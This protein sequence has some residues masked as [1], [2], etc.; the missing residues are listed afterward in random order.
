M[1]KDVDYLVVFQEYIGEVFGEDGES[2]KGVSPDDFLG[3]IDELVEVSEPVDEAS[4]D[5][6]FVRVL[7]EAAEE[8]G[9]CLPV[10]AIRAVDHF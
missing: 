7:A 6:C 8:Q 4:F 2:T 9:A 3:V 5:I 1:L 10:P